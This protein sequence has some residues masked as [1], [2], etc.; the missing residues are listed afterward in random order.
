[1]IITPVNEITTLQALLEQY[2]M[3]IVA[4]ITAI[5]T[6]NETDAA[7]FKSTS[8]VP[9]LRASRYTQVLR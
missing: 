1:M 3:A 4:C 6:H 9:G 8:P 5:E 2:T 7:L